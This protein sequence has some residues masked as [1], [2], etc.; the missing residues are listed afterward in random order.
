MNS[1]KQRDSLHY[2]IRLACPD[3][4]SKVI[5]L[6]ITQHGHNH[7]NPKL[8]QETYLST[9]IQ[10]RSLYFAVVELED[11][12]LGGMTGADT[13]NLFPG[14]LVIN[15][16]TTMPHI[17]GFGLGKQLHQFLLQTLPIH[18]YASVYTHCL[19]L[20]TFSQAICL[21][22]GYRMTGLLLNRYIYD[23]RAENFIG[24]SLPLKRTH[25]IACRPQ[26]K[27]DAGILYAPPSQE[28]FIGE[29]YASLGVAYRLNAQGNPGSTPPS[30]SVYTLTQ[31]GD[32]RYCEVMVQQAGLDFEEL[33]ETILGR[34]GALE[35]Q[36]FNV[37][38]NLN[39][40]GVPRAY[41][42][43]EERGFF[44][45]GLQPL[46]GPYEYMILHY[47]PSLPV[48]VDQIKVVSPFQ[49]S[50]AYIRQGFHHAHTPGEAEAPP[51]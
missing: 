28:R 50:W 3:E 24:L 31:H 29:T 35:Q 37:Y 14:S 47:S 26:A 32:H 25:L 13:K 23:V 7:A 30:Q 45:T 51:W 11:G 17:R 41:A 1:S 9:A 21:D 34:Y 22:L 49:A 8:Y 19:T 4:A 33:R 27:Q 6:L 15:L 2:T 40:P 39:D 10:E 5:D 12:T 43:L 42:L 36:T 38:L 18:A 48:P 16:L 44:F 46:A 20:D